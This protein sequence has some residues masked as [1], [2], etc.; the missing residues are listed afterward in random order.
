MNIDSGGG[1]I[2]THVLINHAIFRVYYMFVT[3]IVQIDVIFIAD[4]LLGQQ[5]WYPGDRRP[6]RSRQLY[7]LTI[8]MLILQFISFAENNNISIN[9]KNKKKHLKIKY[10]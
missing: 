10:C 3:H 1:R 8:F 9:L 2:E 4:F 5:L 7:R 6:L